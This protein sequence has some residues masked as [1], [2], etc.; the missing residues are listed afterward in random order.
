MKTKE[1]KN[2]ET[3]TMQGILETIK[4]ER[5][6]RDV[7]KVLS[8]PSKNLEFYTDSE[9]NELIANRKEAGWEITINE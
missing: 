1:M 7:N 9:L 6:Q 8:F 5:I 4:V 2:F 3:I